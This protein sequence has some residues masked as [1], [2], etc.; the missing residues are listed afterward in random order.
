MNHAMERRFLSVKLK[1]RIRKLR[2]KG[3]KTKVTD[4][5]Q[6]ASSF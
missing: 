4:E 2:Y 3:E 1:A 5:L 6:A